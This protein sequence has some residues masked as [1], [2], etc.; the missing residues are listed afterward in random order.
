MH[1]GSMSRRAFMRATGLSAGALLA[2]PTRA[3][4]PIERMHGPYMKLSLAAYSFHKF[5]P[6]RKPAEEYAKADMNLED[7]VR[8][9]AELNLDACEPTSYYFPAEVTPE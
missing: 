3:A 9:C 1:L 5:L 2:K 6:N 4:S 7:F 8:Y